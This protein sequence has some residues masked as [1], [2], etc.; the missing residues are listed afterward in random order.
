MS[1]NTN[2]RRE[3]ILA[4]TD[5]LNAA[6]SRHGISP[7]GGGFD[8]TQLQE[9]VDAAQRIVTAAKDPMGMGMEAIAQLSVITANRIFWEWGVFEA[10]PV[11]GSTTWSDLAAK[12]DADVSLISEYWTALPPIALLAD[13]L[14]TIST[15]GGSIGHIWYLGADGLRPDQSYA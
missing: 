1:F 10:I 11:E 7:A 4:A 5:Q 3:R 9:I 15:D 12:V 6:V 8:K 2:Q 13:K 14:L